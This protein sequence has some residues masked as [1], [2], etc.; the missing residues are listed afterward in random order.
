MQEAV[1][2]AY[3]AKGMALEALK[4]EV[5]NLEQG[6]LPWKLVTHLHPDTDAMVCI[7]A[8]TRF[9]V[10][11]NEEVSYH[12]VRSGETLLPDEMA[13]FRVLHMDTGLGELDQHALD[14]TRTSSFEL[15]CKKYGWLED[16]ALRPILEMTIATDNVEVV[17]PTSVHYVLKGLHYHF[18]DKE[19]KESDWGE[20]CGNAFLILDLLYGQWKQK[21]KARK[22]LTVHAGFNELKGGVRFTTILTRPQLRDAAYENGADVVM[23][24]HVLDWKKRDK[25][26][27]VGIQVNRMST[28]TLEC[29]MADIRE[30][31]AKK[32]NVSVEGK[33]L[34]A[35]GKD[36]A[37][38][39][40][41]LHGSKKLIVCGSRSN[42]LAEGEQTMLAP[43]EI[44]N[45][46]RNRLVRVF[47]PDR[48][49]A[50]RQAR[51]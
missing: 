3:A 45:I 50:K 51:R 40:W 22:D 9:L 27:M 48:H 42:P 7:W 39:G 23:W 41:Y 4:A 47:I 8:A 35:H 6:E 10:G 34:Q 37:F 44:V 17:D 2:K 5:P 18:Y 21:V 1:Q 38:G 49:N 33:N 32:R 31:E 14:Y 29:V 20:V 11:T 30:A 24:T 28:V 46:I 43:G 26:F 36:S 16:E 13:G 19:T 25:D 12:F 15:M